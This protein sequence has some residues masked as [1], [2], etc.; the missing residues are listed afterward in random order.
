MIEW[1]LSLAWDTL[2]IDG[3][4][5]FFFILLEILGQGYISMYGSDPWISW[6]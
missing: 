6:R 3:G 5:D 1:N 4:V 2:L